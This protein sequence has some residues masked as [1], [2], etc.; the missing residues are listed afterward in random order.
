[1]GLFDAFASIVNT[2]G[3]AFNTYQTNHVNREVAT[4][5]LN[6]QKERASIEDARYA[7]ETAY[8]R[9]FA[10]DQ[11]DYERALQQ[12]IF[13]REDTALERQA[14]SLSSMG[15]NPLSQQLNGLGA[16]QALSASPAPSASGRSAEVPQ[17]G[18]QAQTPKFD[19]NFGGM[20]DEVNAIDNLNTRGVQ[21][22]LLRQQ[23]TAQELA[24]Q[25]KAIENLI[26]MDKYDISVDKDGNLI[27]NRKFKNKEQD[28][29]ELEYR[30]KTSS[31]E[32]NERENKHQ[33]DFGTHDN[34]STRS[35]DI[36]DVARQAERALTATQ[37]IGNNASKASK[38]ASNLLLESAKK[39]M[40]SAKKVVNKKKDSIIDWFK[41]HTRSSNDMQF[42]YGF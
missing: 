2:A 3:N 13:D 21:R 10:E 28:T 17:D 42:Y 27:L 11:R 39:K 1:M 7:D 35:N 29:A 30:D 25:E 38:E 23:K 16:G 9:A 14:S 34:S 41:N 37:Q 40:S 20:L 15:I 26:K 31:V 24:N 4:D 36:S 18:F 6:Y 32:R 8:N 33:I 5:N 22:D 12:Q 19:L